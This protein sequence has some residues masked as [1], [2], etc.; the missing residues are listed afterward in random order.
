MPSVAIIGGGIAGLSACISLHKYGVEPDVYERS[1]EWARRGHG[2]IL[3]GNGLD[4]LDHLGLRDAICARGH[5]V[6]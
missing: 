2:F 1:S 6:N 5:P 3:L 4:A